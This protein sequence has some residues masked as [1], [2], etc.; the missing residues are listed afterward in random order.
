MK[1]HQRLRQIIHGRAEGKLKSVLVPDIDNTYHRI[2]DPVELID[3][4]ISRNIEHFNQSEGT[5]F[6]KRNIQLICAQ[7]F[8]TA[9]Q[10]LQELTDQGDEAF[11]AIIHGLQTTT[12]NTPQLD[13][14]LT[15]ADMIGKMKNWRESTTTSPSGCHLGLYRS[16]LKGDN[17]AIGTSNPLQDKD[18]EP[19]HGDIFFDCIAQ[20]IN[21]CVHTGYILPLWKPVTN[22]MLEKIPGQPIISKLRVIH[23]FEADFNAWA[24]IVFARRLMKQAEQLKALGDEQGGS[25]QGRTCVD[26][27]A[28]KFFSFEISATTRTPLA[29]MDNDAKACYDRIVMALAYLR[30]QQLGME[31]KPC[32]LLENFLSQAQYHGKAL[33]INGRSQIAWP[34]P[35]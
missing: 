27:Y 9:M 16:I 28:M 23:L 8:N 2:S 35:R 33:W 11:D 24:G 31:H 10:L 5:A 30:S 12:T 7:S 32:V 18:E 15:G 1:S 25:R 6:T 21:I 3:K 34:R 19:N 26:V 29:V 20:I 22:V 17:P 13:G 4:L 14:L